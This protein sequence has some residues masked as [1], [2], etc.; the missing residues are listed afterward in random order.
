VT[1]FV[2]DGEMEASVV[3]G[4]WAPGTWTVTTRVVD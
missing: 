1:E 3:E 4:S 2:Y